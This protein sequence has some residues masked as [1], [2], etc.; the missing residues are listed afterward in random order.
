MLRFG[1]FKP[2]TVA[3]EQKSGV[4]INVPVES[5]E[6]EDNPPPSTLMGRFPPESVHPFR[7]VWLGSTTHNN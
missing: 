4:L 6:E 1:E 7:S 2:E 5:G 3:K